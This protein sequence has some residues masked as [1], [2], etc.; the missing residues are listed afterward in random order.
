MKGIWRQKYDYLMKEESKM[1][2]H[3]DSCKDMEISGKMV[4]VSVLVRVLQSSSS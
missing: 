4:I 2:F 1:G 3:D